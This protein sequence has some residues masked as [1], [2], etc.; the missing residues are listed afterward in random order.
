MK[1]LKGIAKPPIEIRRK[2]IS[3]GDDTGDAGA[4][5]GGKEDPRPRTSK[6]RS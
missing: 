4:G 2:R 6:E 1:I 5:G 3:V